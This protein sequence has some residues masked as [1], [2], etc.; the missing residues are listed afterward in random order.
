MRA[1]AFRECDYSEAGQ[2]GEF[3]TEAEV[4][5]FEAARHEDGTGSKVKF[6]NTPRATVAAE[7]LALEATIAHAVA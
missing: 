1:S 2:L 6:W 5:A 7:Q 4:L 3:A